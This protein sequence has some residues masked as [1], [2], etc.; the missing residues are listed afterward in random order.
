MQQQTSNDQPQAPQRDRSEGVRS[1][2]IPNV[3]SIRPTAEVVEL[4]R[5]VADVTSRVTIL[6]LA[7][8]RARQANK[9]SGA[10]KAGGRTRNWELTGRAWSAL[11][12]ELRAWTQMVNVAGPHVSAHQVR[13][14]MAQATSVRR[15]ADSVQRALSEAGYPV[16]A[17]PPPATDRSRP[18]VVEVAGNIA[19]VDVGHN[20]DPDAP[21]AQPGRG[22]IVIPVGSPDGVLPD[23]GNGGVAAISVAARWVIDAI[24]PL[25]VPAGVAVAGEAT[26]DT[27]LSHVIYVNPPVLDQHDPS[28]GSTRPTR[29]GY[30]SP[31][32]TASTR[33]QFSYC[34]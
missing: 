18:R 9:A 13:V 1:D 33:W 12:S 32:R 4:R 15:L 25:G 28:A 14:M 8:D 23:V 29:M 7:Y 5:A 11:T 3:A 34:R 22:G 27:S 17:P 10:N 20:P 30:C 31:T 24:H 16:S 6:G 26:G 2:P 21:S 19:T